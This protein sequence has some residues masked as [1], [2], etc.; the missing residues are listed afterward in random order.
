MN[1]NSMYWMRYSIDI[2]KKVS[3]SLLQV[4]I[5][6]VSEQNKLLC[7][8]Y[9]GEN[10]NESWYGVL[11]RKIQKLKLSHAQSIYLTINTLSQDRSFD[12][13][14]LLKKISVD[15]IY[16]GLP[17]PNLTCYWDNDPAITFNCVYRYP[18]KLQREILD[19]NYQFFSE[20]KQN[21]K[22]SPYYSEN[23][24]SNLVIEKLK[25]RGF[26]ISKDELNEN[27]RESAMALILCDRYGIEYSEAI[28]IV[29]SVVSEA[30]SSKYASYNY[31]DDT[32]S[33]DVNWKENFISVYKR[34]SG[35]NMSTLNILNVGVGGGHEAIALFSNCTHITFVDIV[36]SSLE[37]IKEHI[38]LSKI[39]VSSAENLF[40]IPDNSYDL[41]VSLRTYNSSFFDI[42]GAISEAH[43]V[44][45]TDA[46]IIISVAN[47]FLCS[48]KHGV[49]PG[50]I[51]PGTE[52]VDIYR[53]IS[54]SKLIHNEF[55]RLGFKNVQLIPTNT[56][57]YLS[58]IAA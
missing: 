41:Y 58:A 4:G 10:F 50:L 57:I 2:S 14:E 7:S 28:N 48:E 23:R 1:D 11:L 9:S 56:E 42:K 34:S 25:L 40:S 43:R 32:R 35:K 31:A 15:E 54:T 8:A 47:G 30:F 38:P 55:V 52:F 17:D 44:L 24:I 45:K 6:L 18:D 3:P 5:V 33:L 22:Y 16:V 49:V 36:Q 26:V 53:G 29:C 19:Q 39:I 12:L 46:V 13:I 21:I 27:K 20:S 37:K 51:I